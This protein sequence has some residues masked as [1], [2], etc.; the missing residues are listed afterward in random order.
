M[1]LDLLSGVLVLHLMQAINTERKSSKALLY[2]S[3]NHV[4]FLR[5]FANAVET[6]VNIFIATLWL[7][8]VI[9]AL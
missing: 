8:S 4:Y 2:V 3:R 6:F 1:L 7:F 5:T 9:V